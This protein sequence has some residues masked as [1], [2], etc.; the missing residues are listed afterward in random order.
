MKAHS[1]ILIG[2][3]LLLSFTVSAQE[4]Y[5]R[6]WGTYF[7][8]EGLYF[9][10]GAVDKDGN[11]YLVGHVRDVAQPFYSFTDPTSHQPEYGGGMSDGFIAKFN[12]DGNLLW[13]TYYGGAE[14]DRIEDIAISENDELYI[15]GS[16]ISENNI[17]TPGA[18]QPQLN[19]DKD[20]LLAKFTLDGQ[21]LW[22]TYFGGTASEDGLGL[23][24]D[25]EKNTGIA[26]HP[27][28]SIFIINGTQSEGLGTAST[29][30]P[31][32][33]GSKWLIS[34]FSPEGDR[35][36][37][38]YYGINWGKITG[39]ALL[40]NE[41]IVAG[42]HQDCP[43]LFEYNTYYGTSNGY[44][45][46]PNDCRGAFISKFSFDGQRLWGSYFGAVSVL[47]WG[48][49]LETFGENIYLGGLSSYNEYIATPG[50]YQETTETTTNFLEKFNGAGERLWGTFC[51]D[52]FSPPPTLNLSWGKASTDVEGN[53][54][55][56]G[57]TI[58]DL[59]I[60]SPGSYQEEIAG[61]SD[62]FVVKFNPEGE[63]LWGTYYG[64]EKD[65]HNSVG[66]PYGNGFYVVGK[67]RSLTNIAIP[68]SY[69]P[70][71][72]SNDID[73]SFV[74]GNIYIARFGPETAS[75]RE[76]DNSSFTLYPNPN[77]GTFTITLNGNL[78]AETSINVYNIMGQ[79][80]FEENI[81]SQK[82]TITLEN[83]HSGIYFVKIKSGNSVLKTEKMI[84]N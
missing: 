53:I 27:N 47:M 9:K 13:G 11:L 34:K 28:G 65:E 39:I 8:N 63:R 83:L 43:P 36:W 69:Q 67:T 49:S 31:Q 80:L 71:Y 26:V 55:I 42:S 52:N 68:N 73:I 15:I 45:S 7:G 58:H 46:Q 37:S 21:L 40:G 6:L 30:Q 5:E 24:I 50:A 29:F 14:M 33:E 54:Y 79:L 22:G 41:I 25:Y 51:G 75:T 17:A 72:I 12:S 23:E 16:T 32:I 62:A 1:Y 66:I 2:I 82:A 35:I 18:Y 3:V 48:K 70:E 84:V 38:T 19:G 57:K 78:P 76:F 60:A 20:I 81:H 59:N 56:S 10:E 77:D 64:G 74:P 44:Q 61:S 4:N